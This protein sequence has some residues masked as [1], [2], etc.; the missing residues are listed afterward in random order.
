MSAA[1]VELVQARALL[2]KQEKR[3]EDDVE[4]DMN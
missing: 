2:S 3:D 1:V 4:R